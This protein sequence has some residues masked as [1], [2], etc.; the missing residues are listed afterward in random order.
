MIHKQLGDIKQQSARIKK[1]SNVFFHE[2]AHDVICDVTLNLV[3]EE[4]STHWL[5]GNMDMI[6]NVQ[7]L[8]VYI[9][10]IS[11]KLP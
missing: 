6:W 8:L 5:L 9:L 4:E 11:M 1:N 10:S 2:N 3:Q 7:F